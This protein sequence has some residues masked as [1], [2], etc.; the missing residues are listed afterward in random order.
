M[1]KLL[2]LIILS[3]MLLVGGILFGEAAMGPMIYIVLCDLLIGTAVG[4]VEHAQRS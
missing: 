4:V 2:G 3:N 1:V